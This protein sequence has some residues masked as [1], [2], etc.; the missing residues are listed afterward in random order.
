V[1]AGGYQCESCGEYIE[2]RSPGYG[3]D[4][5][6]V[7]LTGTHTA[8]VDDMDFEEISADTCEENICKPCNSQESAVKAEGG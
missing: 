7:C 1:C 4:N 3:F 5:E 8:D 6:T 2:E